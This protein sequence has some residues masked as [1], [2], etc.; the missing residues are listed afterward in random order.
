MVGTPLLMAATSLMVKPGDQGFFSFLP[1]MAA[2][3]PPSS[4]S[5]GRIP[6]TTIL[7]VPISFI[8]SKIDCF[9][10]V[11]IA[12]MAITA[13]TPKI[14]PKAVNMALNW[15]AITPSKAK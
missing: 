15:F 3:L 13:P 14:I 12:N 6:F 7:L 11:P 5:E 2:A 8:W 9:A 4:L 1:S 10:P